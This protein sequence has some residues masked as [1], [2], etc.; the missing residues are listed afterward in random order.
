MTRDNMSFDIIGGPSKFDLMSSLFAGNK[1][2]TV[3]LQLKGARTPITVAIT[4]V[5]QEDGS[6]EIWSI[7]GWVTD[8]PRHFGIKAYYSSSR[9]SRRKGCLTFITPFHHV[10]EGDEKHKVETP[11]DQHDM[12]GYI[13]QLR[14]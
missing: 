14:G 13:N 11:E 2:Q 12:A 5:Q 4:L 8:H 9:H 3:E 1:R 7:E 6:G 10:I